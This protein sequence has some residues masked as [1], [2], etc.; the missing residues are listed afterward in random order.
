M[1]RAIAS[2]ISDSEYSPGGSAASQIACNRISRLRRFGTGH[3]RG[4]LSANAPR[5]LSNAA[6]VILSGGDVPIRKVY[7]T[8]EVEGAAQPPITSSTAPMR[9]DGSCA[10]SYSFAMELVTSTSS[11][12]WPAGSAG[13]RGNT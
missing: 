5:R 2:L 13:S 11:R 7:S 9:P 8:L 4:P 10:P 12:W 1:N 3:T 6:R